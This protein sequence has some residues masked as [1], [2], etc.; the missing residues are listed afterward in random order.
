MLPIGRA[1]YFMAMKHLH[2]SP[3]APSPRW[4]LA[5]A[6]KLLAYAFRMLG[7]R[8]AAEDAVQSAF[9]AWHQRRDIRRHEAWLMGA[10]INQCRL[11]LRRRRTDHAALHAVRRGMTLPAM[12]PDAVGWTDEE[13]RV[14]QALWGL[15]PEQREVVLLRMEYDRTYAEI[16]DMLGIPEG[17]AKTRARAA[18]ES[19]QNFFRT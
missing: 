10:T 14:M 3:Q 13:Q 8:Q 9:M 1:Q 12:P 5:Q 4:V 2:D 19:L 16:G 17:T 6:E 15:T 11:E 7:D 18:A